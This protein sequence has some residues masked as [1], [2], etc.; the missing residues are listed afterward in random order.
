MNARLYHRGIKIADG[1]KF[2]NQL[3]FKQKDVLIIWVG[4]TE[5]QSHFYVE[6]GGRIKRTSELA[7]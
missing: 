3:I 6:E 1:I 5:E 7:I 4:S 2:A